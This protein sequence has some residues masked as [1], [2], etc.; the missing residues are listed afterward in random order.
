MILDFLFG[1]GI[2]IGMLLWLVA[3]FS[4]VWIWGG[5]KRNALGQLAAGLL[6]LVS[7]TLF[8]YVSLI[9]V[10]ARMDNAYL[11]NAWFGGTLILGGI[12]LLFACLV[13]YRVPLWLAGLLL[14]TYIAFAFFGLSALAQLFPF[15]GSA[16]LLYPAILIGGVLLYT[17]IRGYALDVLIAVALSGVGLV[18]VWTIY[19]AGLDAFTPV[20][21]ITS[22]L[23]EPLVKPPVLEV[24]PFLACVL[25]AVVI[26]I[27]AHFIPRLWRRDMPP[28][29]S[30]EPL[31]NSL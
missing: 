19:G 5:S 30:G 13:G 4:T 8:I 28:G 20:D 16:T 18:L 27:G 23:S 2:W 3:C 15:R 7:G 24:G 21:N 10:Y 31:V 1:W 25:V 22:S 14:A 11:S 6:Q 9:N 29:V 12:I 17:L 26:Y